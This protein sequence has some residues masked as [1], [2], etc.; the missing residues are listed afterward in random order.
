[1]GVSAPTI[2]SLKAGGLTGVLPVCRACHHSGA[3]AF[4]AIGLPDD[5]P[6]PRI[7]G[8]RRFRCSGC[9]ARDY[10]VVPGWRG[11]RAPGMGKM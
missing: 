5:T 10:A 4:D 9:G 2:A 8:A 3:V 6:F 7:A 1:M 11:Y